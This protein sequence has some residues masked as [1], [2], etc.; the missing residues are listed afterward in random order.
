M[1]KPKI[2]YYIGHD[3]TLTKEELLPWYKRIFKKRWEHYEETAIWV[4]K[5]TYTDAEEKK[6]RKLTAYTAYFDAYDV[7]VIV[8]AVRPNTFKESLDEITSGKY[9][10]NAKD[11]NYLHLLAACK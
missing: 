6:L 3:G 4:P 2:R 10:I 9:Y 1:K 11:K 8:N 7:I 5:K